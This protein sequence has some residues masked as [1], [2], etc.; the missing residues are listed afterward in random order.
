MGREQNR[1]RWRRTSKKGSQVHESGGLGTRRP[2]K[3][4]SGDELATRLLKHGASQRTFGEMIEEAVVMWRISDGNSVSELCSEIEEFIANAA[5][6]AAAAMELVQ[7]MSGPDERHLYTALKKYVE[8]TGQAL[9]E[10]DKR[11]KSVGSSLGKLFPELPEDAEDGMSWRS[12]IGRRDVI[13]HRLLSMDD[14]RV[15]EEA[16][17]DFALLHLLLSSIYFSPSITDIRGGRNLSFVSKAELLRQLEPSN[18]GDSPFNIGSSIV[19]VF[20]DVRLGLQWLRIARTQNDRMLI[21][22]SMEG[23]GRLAVHA[24]N[25]PGL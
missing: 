9:K 10:V 6:N 18:L 7:E 12:L 13:A 19:V 22:S 1:R 23:A 17:R 15:F 4:V 16:R 21:A 24:A 2:A 3:T 8:D 11:L 5:R 20:E 25:G 14:N